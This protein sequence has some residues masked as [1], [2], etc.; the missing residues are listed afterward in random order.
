MPDM[1]NRLERLETAVA[2][3]DSDADDEFVD[4]RRLSAVIDRLQAKQ[5]R[6]VA[7]ATKRGEHLLAGRSAA[8]WVARE[9]RL[10]KTAAADRLCVG[11]QLPKLPAVAT[12]LERGDIGFQAA[13]VLCHLN[14]RF[15]QVG[16][17]IEEEQWIA[18]AREWPVK[19]LMI[20]AAKTWHAVDPS[21]FN[22]K[23]EEAHERR[24]LFISECGDMYRIDGWLELS[25]GPVVK[26]AIDALSKPLGDDDRRAPKQRRADGLTELANHIL[27]SGVL[28]KRQGARPHLAVHTTIEG[29]KG[30]L[31]ARASELADGTPISSKTV[32]RLAC[33][34]ILHR[35]LKANSMVI[36]VG[37]AY[38]SAQPAQWKGLKARHRTCAWP[39][40]DRPISWT[41][42]HHI[43]FWA[44]GG[45]SNLRKLL[46][47]CHHHHRLV[48]EGGYQIVAVG[49]RFD[50]IAPDRPFMSRRRW[51]EY[52]RRAA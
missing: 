40:C 3:F 52:R 2:E 41:S 30:E 10:S 5:A 43:D 15:E 16:A 13:S 14:E 6:V 27:D 18:H 20:E 47:L 35:V 36:D 33:D 46:P 28:P 38:R 34:G 11:S 42:A 26:A 49:D 39:G 32:Q 8:S 17:A 19:D 24:Q 21:G 48:H 31:G 44:E 1:S 25:A 50:F 7:V 22:L 29:L 4:P 12:A 23:V 37:R 51:G 9:C 45:H